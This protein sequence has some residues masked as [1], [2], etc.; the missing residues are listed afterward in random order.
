MDF[1]RYSTSS[2]A[3]WE[4]SRTLLNDFEQAR[5]KLFY[6]AYELRCAIEAFL[7][8]YICFFHDDQLSKSLKKLYRADNLKH[9]IR[10][11]E[12]DFDKRIEFSNIVYAA[13]DLAIVKI[14]VPDLDKLGAF[15]GRIGDFMHI[16][17]EGMDSDGLDTRWAELEKLVKETQAFMHDLVHPQK[18]RIKLSAEG[19]TLFEE[20][21]TNQKTAEQ[22]KA[23]IGN[24]TKKY[25]TEMKLE[26]GY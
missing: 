22:V 15:Y 12:P 9:E 21:K 25:V 11:V 18:T 19:E 6:V 7:Y 10:K 1:E 2:Y 3:Y 14:P 5:H 20:Y 16:Q 17:K 23:I 26:L 24:N 4:R 8:E 13:M